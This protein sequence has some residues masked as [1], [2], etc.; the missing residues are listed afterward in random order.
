MG[1]IVQSYRMVPQFLLV[2]TILNVFAL[3]ASLNARERS[4][5]NGGDK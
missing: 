1:L 3:S 5:H 4:F 2:H